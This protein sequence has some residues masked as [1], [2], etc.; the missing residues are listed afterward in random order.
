LNSWGFFLS[1][2]DLAINFILNLN[3]SQ[4]AAGTEL[5]STIF[6]EWTML[7]LDSKSLPRDKSPPSISQV[8]SVDNRPFEEKYKYWNYGPE[9]LTPQD[10]IELLSEYKRLALVEHKLVHKN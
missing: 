2:A 8:I 1:N 3:P 7:Q 10:I 6:N 9:N 5:S 4:L